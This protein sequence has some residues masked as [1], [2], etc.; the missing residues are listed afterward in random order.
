MNIK[1]KIISLIACSAVGLNMFAVSALAAEDTGTILQ[2]CT[3]SDKVTLYLSE[4]TGSNA[5]AVMSG[6]EC[7]VSDCGYI[8]DNEEK[9]ETY[10]IIDSSESMK[11]Y[12]D[13]IEQFIDECIDK[14]KDNEYY[15]IGVFSAENAPKYIVEDEN[16]QYTLEKSVSELKY[17]FYSTYIY[18]NILST[19]NEINKSD[20]AGF[21]RIILFTDGSENSAKGITIDDVITQLQKTPVQINT[22][23]FKKD[24]GSNIEEL[25]ITSRLSR[26]SGGYDAR[27]VDGSDKA[28]AYADELYDN[29]NKICRVDIYPQKSLFDGSLRT[30]E[31]KSDSLNLSVDVRTVMLKVEES[32]TAVQEEEPAASETEM[33]E[34]PE[35]DKGLPTLYVIIGAAVVIAALAAVIVI[36]L[37]K[38]KKN[39]QEA[40]VQNS[41]FSEPDS[42]ETVILGGRGGDGDTVMLFD[43]NASTSSVI[44]RDVADSVKTFEV[45]LTNNGVIVGRSADMSS[46][47]IDYDKCISRKHCRIFLK[48]GHAYISDLNSGNKTY[49]NNSEVIGE[50]ILNNADEIKIGKT[51]FKVTIR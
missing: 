27:I 25:K 45:P 41:P 18:N 8:S 28:A 42:G 20:E 21:K 48:N 51:T 14:K 10:F 19:I 49:V 47:V 22:I 50:H 7:D 24:S 46:V 16:N 29:L 11:K 40:P 26:A 36:L 35:E 37:V 2:Y 44:L 4:S 34:E 15:Y 12:S 30:I 6:V 1:N 33:T 43:S 3:D 5:E 38:K 32:V 17:D 39:V 31:L 13:E 23:G 9:I